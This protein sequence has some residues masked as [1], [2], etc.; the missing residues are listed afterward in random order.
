M[1]QVSSKWIITLLPS[2][3]K[4]PRSSPKWARRSGSMEFFRIEFE[5]LNVMCSEWESVSTY[6][7]MV[8][9]AVFS[10]PVN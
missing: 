10:T 1:T 2:S 8:I 5:T 6:D 3:N 9:H 7:G 4:V